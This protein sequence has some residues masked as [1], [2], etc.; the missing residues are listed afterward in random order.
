MNRDQGGDLR[1]VLAL[2][3]TLLGIAIGLFS[4]QLALGPDSGFHITMIVA[5]LGALIGAA[6]VLGHHFIGGEGRV[7]RFLE[8]RLDYDYVQRQGESRFLDDVERL[9]RRGIGRAHPS[10]RT[11]RRR[12][13]LCPQALAMFGR[14]TRDGRFKLCGYTLLYPLCE[15]A[16]ADI[17]AKRIRSGAEIEDGALLK[18]FE[19]AR[20]LYIGMI[21]GSGRHAR[22]HVTA[23]LRSQLIHELN[24]GRVERV[25]GRPATERGKELLQEYGFQAIGDEKDIWSTSGS[26]LLAQLKGR[27]SLTR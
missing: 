12:L 6:L 8:R 5:T 10:A 22:G 26:E 7:R 14:Q 4:V 15:E 23:M 18:A 27:D 25:F 21:F 13:E 19:G 11:M 24:G 3:G 16:G 1:T 20:Y 2:A 9:G 17:C